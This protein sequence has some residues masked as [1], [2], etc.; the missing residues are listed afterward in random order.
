MIFEVSIHPTI[1][2]FVHTIIRLSFHSSFHPLFYPAI[3][4]STSHPFPS[5]TTRLPAFTDLS[6]Y[7]SFRYKAAS[8]EDRKAMEAEEDDILSSVLHNLA[9]F[10]L[11]VSVS[12]ED[13]RKKVNR[14]LG[15]GHLGLNH[16][17]IIYDLLDSLKNLV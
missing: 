3:H 16:T 9:A 1:H 4:A 6:R 2:S 8:A 12:K 10:M 7:F 17:Q 13:L 5:S 11:S 15:Q 14:Y